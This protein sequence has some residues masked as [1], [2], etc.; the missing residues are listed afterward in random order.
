MGKNSKQKKVKS[1]VDCKAILAKYPVETYGEQNKKCG[2]DEGLE[3]E[4][5]E[6]HHVIQNSHFQYP[7]RKTLTEI[8]PGYTEKDAPC[9]P[10]EDSK[11]VNTPHGRVSQMQMTDAT[12]YRQENI[13]PTY[14][15]A[16]E[17]AKKQLMTL[18]KDDGT[19]LTE[20]EAECILVKV[21]EKFEEMCEGITKNPNEELRTPG[22]RGKA[23]PPSRQSGAV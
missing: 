12:R 19:K 2:K 13:T 6:S 3:Y 17:D 10:L 11:D 1:K 18:E 16:R 8:C 9:I 5:Y 14:R 20:D 21:D 15:S 22:A 4:G 23:L 7:R